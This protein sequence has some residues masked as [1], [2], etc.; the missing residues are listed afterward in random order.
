MHT[1]CRPSRLEYG[2]RAMSRLAKQLL[3][4]LFFQFSIFARETPPDDPYYRLGPVHTCLYVRVRE[5]GD[6]DLFLGDLEWASAEN[7]RSDRGL[8]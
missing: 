3:A 6:W 5:T 7:G 4:K 8:I 2:S 1:W